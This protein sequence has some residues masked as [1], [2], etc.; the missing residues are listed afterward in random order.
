MDV[1]SIASGSL[2]DDL[3]IVLHISEAIGL[4]AAD[5]VWAQASLSGNKLDREPIKTGHT[6]S[7]ECSLIWETDRKSIKRMKIENL[8]VKVDLYKIKNYNGD[9]NVAQKE[10]IGYVLLPVRGIPM[11]PVQKAV[12]VKCRWMKIIGLSK[13]FRQHKPELLM[14][15][16]ITDKEFL[17]IDKNKIL[18]AQTIESRESI[19]FE[20]NPNPTMMTSQKGIFIRLLQKEGLLQV[21]SIDTDCD[22]FNVRLLIQNI[23]YLDNI[24]DSA[25]NLSNRDFFI[26]YILLGNNH[27]R[28]LDRKFNRTHQIQE[29]ISINFRSSLKSLH[30]YFENIFYVPVEIY[31]DN[32]MIG[33][34]EIR[35][36]QLITSF[37]LQEFIDKYPKGK[38]YDGV[39]T[40]KTQNNV[41][42]QNRPILEYKVLIIYQGTRKLHQNE[43]FE[44]YASTE[45][46]IDEKAGGDYIPNIKAQSNVEQIE[47]ESSESEKSSAVEVKSV[48]IGK[49]KTEQDLQQKASQPEKTN[50][51][52]MLKDHECGKTSEIQRLFS[53]NLQLKSMKFNKKPH[54]GIWQISFFHEFAD[55][56]RTIVNRDIHENDIDGNVIAFKDLEM[57]LY[58]TSHS[59]NIMDLIKS[60]VSCTM[61]I[62]GPH[63]T[64]AK[65]YLD[66]KNLLIS[67]KEK[68][69][70]N[71]L[72]TNQNETVS[73]MAEIFVYLDDAGLNFNAK[74]VENLPEMN[75]DPKIDIA[76]TIE[77]QKEELFD[78]SIAYKMINE[79][80]DWKEHQQTNFL[81]ELK[82]TEEKYLEKLRTDF[83]N[84]KA[85]YEDKFEEKN[86]ELQVL[87]KTLED[88]HNSLKQKNLQHVRNEDSAQKMKQ[89]LEKSYAD[90]LLMI[91]ER[92]KQ[93]EQEFMH[94]LNMKNLKIEELECSNK[95]L[96]EKVNFLTHENCDL[97][98]KIDCMNAKYEDLKSNLV[99][100]QEVENLIQEMRLLKEK[101]DAAT[102]S[103]NFYK[104]QWAKA[105]RE[106]HKINRVNICD[107]K[108]N[109]FTTKCDRLCDILSDESS[110]LNFDKEE[111]DEIKHCLSLDD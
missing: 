34:V 1:A 23:K 101:F 62:R 42:T 60:T 81:F 73:A 79:L 80:E 55:T 104:E 69:C 12:K 26:N 78:E 82:R 53:Y 93:L 67:N 39:E 66:C 88:A 58:F 106:C 20:E 13:D 28:K 87:T 14:N 65:A 25:E 38:E 86:N 83:N 92:T 52:S 6:T 44:N 32:K 94:E 16:M 30:N 11:L 18:E 59:E 4:N 109:L 51:D 111:L 21:G 99:P 77:I 49:K 61:C 97:K 90:K 89:E 75:E 29:K 2:H 47:D 110:R 46:K 36:D 31:S 9:I 102:Q 105:I 45:M 63:N 74:R 76:K 3:V 24:F 103:K 10:H 107:R 15:I 68:T 98:G 70:G 41:E 40:I 43:L 19:M 96:Y 37:S 48:G 85:S 54:K 64:H 7:F 22:I 17:S 71:I 95:Q 50:I 57:K 91:K 108:D 100:K 5:M 35:L 72:L 8:P 84:M 56:P 27:S 33:S